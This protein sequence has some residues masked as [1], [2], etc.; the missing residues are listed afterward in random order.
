MPVVGRTVLPLLVLGVAAAVR[1]WNLN[2]LPLF[3]DESLWL[4]WAL[5][6]YQYLPRGAGFMDVLRVSLIGDI[7]PPLLHWVLLAVLPWV[8]QPVLGGRATT[9][10]F[11]AFA[12]LGTYL[13]GTELFNRRVGVVA[14][15]IHAFLPLAVFFDRFIHYDALTATCV[16]YTA[17]LSARLARRPGTLGAIALGAV[18]AAAVIANPRGAT[19]APAPALAMLL[20][21][22]SQPLSACL[23]AL[24]ISYLVAAMLAPLTFIGIPLPAIYEKI[25]GFGLTPGEVLEAPTALWEQNMALLES[26]VNIYLGLDLLKLAGLGT[27]VMLIRKP[28]AGLYVLILWLCLVL[29]FIL[30]GR[31]IYSRYLAVSAFPPAVA[32]GFLVIALTSLPGAVLSRLGVAHRLPQTILAVA[33]ALGVL[34]IGVLPTAQTAVGLVSHPLTVQLPDSDRAQYQTGWYSGH[35]VP[36][37]ATFVL[38]KSEE[39]PLILLRDD[40]MPGSGVHFYTYRAPHIRHVIEPGL[41]FNRDNTV[42]R[43]R[44]WLTESGEVYFVVIEDLSGQR[45][46]RSRRQDE[47]LRG[48]Q[49]ARRV[50]E[51]PAP[52]G[53]SQIVVFRVE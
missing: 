38:A 8:D 13:L 4:R 14:G 15:F 53:Q 29:P 25:F 32:T 7:N 26:W 49:E 5:N 17:W 46:S 40:G 50:A 51:Y 31:Q 10:T 22:G 41:A 30:G 39:S 48:F 36:E 24:G 34:Y 16:V 19:I 23:P 20:L 2:G 9:A 52:D 11:G 43:I 42:A 45:P 6:P 21:R 3:I 33:A 18:L 1:F 47:V 27:L 44:R 28:G 12:A 35:G 37:A